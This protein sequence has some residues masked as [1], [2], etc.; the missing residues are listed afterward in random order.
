MI[1]GGGGNK[2]EG[3]RRSEGKVGEGKKVKQ[4]KLRRM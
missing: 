1:R 3:S 4:G 2:Q